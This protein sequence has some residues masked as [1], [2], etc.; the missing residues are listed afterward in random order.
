MDPHKF[1]SNRHISIPTGPEVA[2]HHE[3]E[4]THDPV[5]SRPSIATQSVSEGSYYHPIS[6]Y[7]GYYQVPE[8]NPIAAH[9]PEPQKRNRTKCHIERNGW[10]L[11]L[12]IVALI[13][14]AA[15][16]GGV[17]GSLAV[18][19]AKAAAV[20]ANATPTSSAPQTSSTATSTSTF[21]TMPTDVTRGDVDVAVALDCPAI[22][23]RS[24]T[25]LGS[26]WLPACGLDFTGSG[27]PSIDILAATTYSWEDCVRAC[28]TYNKKS[29]SRGCVGITF[30]ADLSGYVKAYEGNCF[31]KNATTTYE[32]TGLSNRR[33]VLVVMYGIRRPD[34]IDTTTRMHNAHMQDTITIRTA[35]LV[36]PCAGCDAAS[37]VS[38]PLRRSATGARALHA[39]C[40]TLRLAV[41]PNPGGWRRLLAWLKPLRGQ[42]SL[43]VLILIQHRLRR[44]GGSFPHPRSDAW[45]ISSIVS[46][47]AGAPN[48]CD[49]TMASRMKLYK[50]VVLGDGGVGKTALT[51][52]LC[53][54]H[55]VETY[56]PTLEDSYRKQCV[57][58]DQ[59]CMLEVLDTAGQEEYTALRE[60]WIRDGDVFLLVFSITS[61]T[62]FDGV[63]N[64]YR[65]LQHVKHYPEDAPMPMILVGNKTDLATS[66]A[67]STQEGQALAKEFKVAYLETSA[68][69]GTNVERAFYDLVRLWKRQKKNEDPDGAKSHPDSWPATPSKG[70]WKTRFSRIFGSSSK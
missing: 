41:A 57:I 29:G 20:T 55:F 48:T 11:I 64:F 17:G 42:T 49:D 24:T 3:K 54:Q 34:P 13:V 63:R 23:G 68:K 8:S 14:G 51:S 35:A 12:V 28:A 67:V 69:D 43:A 18:E 21:Y 47:L 70:K 22:D 44:A 25:I 7:T 5:S 2:Q 19:R 31:L 59:T 62:T 33:T 46:P 53:Y 45:T 16:G 66:R 37:T 58:D 27:N 10:I 56:D 30:N 61:R 50:I 65:Q 15:V 60:Q 40:A 1:L 6:Q 39:I 32:R 4:A 36:N 26:T 52:R 38:T 9:G